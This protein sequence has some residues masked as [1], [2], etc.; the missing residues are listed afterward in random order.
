MARLRFGAYM[1]SSILCDLI[2]DFDPTSS[3]G[4][5]NRFRYFIAAASAN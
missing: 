2:R 4:S 5:T 3:R 1:N